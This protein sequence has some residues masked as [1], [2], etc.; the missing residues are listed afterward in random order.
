MRPSK[1]KQNPII[2]TRLALKLH[3]QPYGVEKH[4][5]KAHLG[6]SLCAKPLLSSH[7][8]A[9]IPFGWRILTGHVPIRLAAVTVRSD[10]MKGM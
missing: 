4:P 3:T 7:V 1:D 10:V 6:T 9:S 2:G 8:N 5:M